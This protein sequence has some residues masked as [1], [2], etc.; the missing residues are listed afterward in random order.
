MSREKLENHRR[1]WANKEILRTIYK[2][3]F[4]KVFEEAKKGISLEI[5]SG[6]GMFKSIYPEVI[7]T[8]IIPVPWLDLTCNAQ[9][10]PFKNKSVD[11][12]ILIDVIHHIQDPL[13]FFSEGVRIMKPGGR[14]LIID[15]HLSPFS[16][17]ALRLFHHERVDSKVDPFTLLPAHPSKDPFEGNQAMATL[18]FRKY[19][20]K[21]QEQFP[22]LQLQKRE[23]FSTITYPLSGGFEHHGFIR[24]KHYAFLSRIESFLKILTPLLAFR[25]FLVFKKIA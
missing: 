24:Q 8:D 4:S 7:A 13:M 21:F 5:G 2:D 9:E 22:T 3:W 11:N 19:F 15:V 14:I 18:L 10:L 17:I 25:T 1:I 6:P 16:T 20:D 12:I 23:I